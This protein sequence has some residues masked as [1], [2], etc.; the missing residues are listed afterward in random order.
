MLATGDAALTL[1]NGQ[2]IERV[3]LRNGD[4]IEWGGVKAR[5]WIS[6]ARQAGLRLRETLTWLGLFA[7][8]A[9]EVGLCWWLCQ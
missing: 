8:M 1:V 6:P 2:P 7:F 4:L 5:F 9:A 3:R